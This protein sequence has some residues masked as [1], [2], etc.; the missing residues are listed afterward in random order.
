MTPW[1][2]RRTRALLFPRLSRPGMRALFDAHG[3]REEHADLQHLVL[4]GSWLF[5]VTLLAMVGAGT[6]RT[7]HALLLPTGLGPLGL[8]EWGLL[9]TLVPALLGMFLLCVTA[10]DAVGLTRRIS[11][12]LAGRV[13]LELRMLQEKDRLESLRTVSGAPVSRRRL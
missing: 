13:P 4:V 5:P 1:W 2:T 8:L 6:C 10:I 3:S 11:R 7:L 12:D 9:L